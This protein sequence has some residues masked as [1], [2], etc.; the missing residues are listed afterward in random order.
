M[1]SCFITFV[2]P[3]IGIFLAMYNTLYSLRQIR[4]LGVDQMLQKILKI[5]AFIIILEAL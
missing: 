2:L 4:P 5:L 3:S 1:N